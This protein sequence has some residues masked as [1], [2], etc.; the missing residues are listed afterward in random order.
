MGHA[1]A[2]AG[3]V[4]PSSEVPVPAQPAEALQAFRIFVGPVP[5][6][7]LTLSI[8]FAWFYP[9]SRQA[10]HQLVRELGQRTP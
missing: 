6:V 9:I 3:Y 8:I 7:L 2:V 10:H 1:L 4:A 5:V